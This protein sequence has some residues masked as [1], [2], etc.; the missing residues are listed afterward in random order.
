VS[1]PTHDDDLE[2]LRAAAAGDEA[3]CRTLHARHVAEARRR[4]YLV[5][6]ST[7]LAEDAT[8]EAFVDLWRTAGSF[9]AKRASVR[10]WLCVLV[11]RRAVDLARREAR[12]RRLLPFHGRPEPGS[13]TAEETLL[14]Q[15]DRRAVQAALQRLGDPR[16]RLLELA[17]YGGL[18]HQ[19]LAARL[20]VPLG[21]LKSRMRTALAELAV[22]LAALDA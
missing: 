6:R 17:F 16:R 18:T 12:R 4:A 13:Y 7:T 21:T 22:L 11:H 15:L 14:L 19:E 8:Q 2:L 10:V 1:E 5:L 3:A 9:D 20:G